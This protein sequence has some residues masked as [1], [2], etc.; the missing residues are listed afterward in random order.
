MNYTKEEFPEILK[1]TKD[2]EIDILR[3]KKCSCLFCRQSY[4][5]RKVSE[6]NNEEKRISAICPECGMDTVVGDASGFNLDHDTLKAINQ[7]YYGEEYMVKNPESLTKFTTRYREGKITK[8]PENEALYA[9]YLLL[10]VKNGDPY[11]AFYLGEI[12]EF[13]TTFTKKNLHEALLWYTDPTLHY[14]VDAADRL[15]CV[16]YKLGSYES[17]YEEFAKAS[18]I[19]SF[20]ALLHFSDCYME[21]RGALRDQEYACR[22]LFSCSFDCFARY[23][24]SE[25][26]IP[27]A[28]SFSSCCYRLGKAYEKGGG[29][30]K[31][32]YIAMRYYLAGDFAYKTLK[33]QSK[34][35]HEHD[36]EYRNLK[37][38]LNSI[39][40]ANDYTHSE[41]MFDLDTFLSSLFLLEFKKDVYNIYLPATLHPYGFDEAGGIFSLGISYPHSQLIIDVQNCF[42]DFVDG[43]IVWNFDHVGKIENFKNGTAFNRVVGNGDTSL[44]FYNTFVNP[45]ELVGEIFF[46]RS[47]EEQTEESK[48]A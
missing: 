42:C 13:G 47:Q 5:A 14:N 25:G 32:V 7:A 1:H 23:I 10:M 36:I 24:M 2:N 19:G 34:L 11:A 27:E 29:I 40:K 43:E 33:N 12:Y 41:P 31:D 3:S 28:L 22:V 15:A 9:H 20:S 18:A 4:D 26:D 6:W 39:M 45:N 46:D 21:G 8:K 44:R 16:L 17:A 48:K 38:H 30:D 37:R 35:D